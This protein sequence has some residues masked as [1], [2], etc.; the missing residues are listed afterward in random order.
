M[1][2]LFPAARS[3][4]PDPPYFFAAATTA[5]SSSWA[6]CAAIAGVSALRK[7][8]RCSVPSSGIT[9]STMPFAGRC[10]GAPAAVSPASA[11][12]LAPPEPLAA[13]GP[14]A[15]VPRGRGGGRRRGDAPSCG[16]FAIG[17]RHTGEFITNQNANAAAADVRCDLENRHAK[18]RP[19]PPSVI[20]SSLSHLDSR[21]RVRPGRLKHEVEPLREKG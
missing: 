8:L 6:Y 21:P 13:P 18:R 4:S 20:L 10:C 9:P 15:S 17:H 14:V 16:E 5:P 12:R 7:R 2:A 1:A 19:R 11:W 3:S